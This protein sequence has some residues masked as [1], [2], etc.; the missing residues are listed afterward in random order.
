MDQNSGLLNLRKD[1]Y[2]HVS[3]AE[4]MR[5]KLFGPGRCHDMEGDGGS[6]ALITLHSVYVMTKKLHV[7]C[8]AKV[9]NMHAH[10][11]RC[12]ALHSC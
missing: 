6:T 10:L 5:H 8:L 11:L 12:C 7:G 4:C 9:V 3:V 2:P 1:C